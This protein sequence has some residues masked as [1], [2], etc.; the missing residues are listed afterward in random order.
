MTIGKVCGVDI[1]YE[2]SAI[3]Y[4]EPTAEATCVDG[5]VGEYE[6]S[7]TWATIRGAAGDQVSDANVN[8]GC[9][10]LTCH[11][12]TADRYV[13][14]FRGIITLLIPSELT[15]KTIT[16]ATLYL[17]GGNK[18]NSFTNGVSPTINIYSSAPASN[19]ALAAGDYDSLGTTAYCD[20]AIAIADWNLSGWNA[21]V[22]N[23]TGLTAVTTA[24]A[25]DR[26][27]KLGIRDHYDATNTAPTWEAG[28][29]YY[30]RYKASESG[31][32][33]RPKLI[34]TYTG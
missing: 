28:K 34:I 29:N 2:K 7:A 8:G 5:E 11:A 21:F 33:F 18:G 19:I 10:Y 14:L 17:Y 9:C 20:S 23:A 16:G 26:Y 4:P 15:G 12:S 25:G 24:L 13:Y 22:F 30:M 6:S 3:L 32:D 27:V 1:D 31:G